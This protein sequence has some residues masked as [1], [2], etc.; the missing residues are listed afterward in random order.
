MVL[1][2][3]GFVVKVH[4]SGDLRLDCTSATLSTAQRLYNYVALLAR[5]EPAH[6]HLDTSILD[7]Y[8]PIEKVAIKQRLPI[9]FSLNRKTGDAWTDTYVKNHRYIDPA[10]CMDLTST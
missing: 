8:N 7:Q 4:P 1:I 9:L 2:Q 6:Q 5:S 10:V 3:F